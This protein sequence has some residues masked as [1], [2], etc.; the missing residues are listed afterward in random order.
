MAPEAPTK[1][2]ELPQCRAEKVPAATSPFVH[3]PRR[4]HLAR[5]ARQCAQRLV[6]TRTVLHAVQAGGGHQMRQ[7]AEVGIAAQRIGLVLD[8]QRTLRRTM[9]PAV[10]GC[11]VLGQRLVQRRMPG[12][13]APQLPPF[14]RALRQAQQAAHRARRGH[15]HRAAAQHQQHEEVQRQVGAPAAEIDADQAVVAAQ[16]RRGHHGHDE[17]Q[18]EPDDAAHARPDAP[19]QRTPA[20]AAMAASVA[21]GRGTTTCRAC[22]LTCLTS[23]MALAVRFEPRS[24]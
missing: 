17:Q 5:Q 14:A 2:V 21:S 23:S 22:A 13:L 24:K 3:R 19:V 18:H 9:G 4:G 6:A 11:K 16:R 1:R 12:T 20:T 10:A 8:G 15:E 7:R